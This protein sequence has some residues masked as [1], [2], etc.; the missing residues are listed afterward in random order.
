MVI[1]IGSEKGGT[2]KTT[3]ATNLAAMRAKNGKEVMLLDT[4]VQ[5]SATFWANTRDTKKISPSVYTVQ[6][7]G[8]IKTIIDKF[9]K[10]FDDIIIDTAGSDS[11]ELRSS[12]ICSDKAYIPIQTSAFDVWTISTMLGIINQVSGLNPKLKSYIILNRASPNPSVNETKDVEN[13]LNDLQGIK[14]S[15]AIIR[16]RIAFRK[17]A[18]DGLAVSEIKTPD[19]KAIEEINKLYKEVYNG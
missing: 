2:G 1:I 14:L 5:K 12:L 4:D 19:K 7:Q 8:N 10:T 16:E 6:K 17:A 13:I 11:E 3:L 9:K 15:G 18:R